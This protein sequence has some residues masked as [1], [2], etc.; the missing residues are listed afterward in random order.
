M[1]QKDGTGRIS[2]FEAPAE[3]SQATNKEQSPE[4]RKTVL[5][6]EK[7]LARNKQSKQNYDK[8]FV[9]NYKFFRGKQWNEAR[10]A[11]R[12]NDVLNFTNAAIQTIIPIMTDSRP[13]I[14]TLPENPADQEFSMIL[15]QVLESKWDRDQFSQIVAEAIVD[16]A[17]YGTAITEQP[18]KPELDQ[19][20]GDFTFSTVD[21]LYC[22]PDGRSRD[23]N[24]NFGHNFITAI[25]WNTG[26]LK[27]KYPDQ[28]H[29]LKSDISDLDQAKTAKIDMDDYRIRTATDSLTLVQGERGTDSD[30][31]DQTLVIT[32]WL[33]DDTMVEEKFLEKDSQGSEKEKFRTKKKFP[34]GRKVVI[35]NK[36]LL[37]DVE[38][39]YIDGK[40]PYAKLVDYILPRE[41]WGEGEVQQLKGP[42]RIIN[43]LW[44][45]VMD[46]LDLMG[47]PV[48]KNPVGS[49]VFDQSI[50]NKPG[51]VIPYNEGSEPTRER[52]TDVQAS[53]FQAFDRMREVFDKISG[54]NDVSRGAIPAGMS[55]IAIEEMK[56]AAETRI[57]LKSRN[58]DAW[59]TAVGQQFVSRVMQFYT[60]ARIVRVTDDQGADK[61]FRFAIDEIEDEKGEVQRVA[62]VQNFREVQLEDGTTQQ[63]EDEPIQYEIKGNLDV[64]IGVGTTLPFRKAQKKALAKELFQLGIYDADDLLTDLEVPNKETVLNK[65]NERQQAA[66]EAE[67]AAAEQ[68]AAMQQAELQI[69]AVAAQPEPSAQA[70]LASV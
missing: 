20:L 19:G 55:G 38:N 23:V 26:E 70:P 42:N 69:K 22:Y 39:P 64:R 60:V 63:V 45:M 30:A 5:M 32:A 62:T 6:V 1:P 3:A 11:Y 27:T 59:L 33:D 34:N 49:G 41:F 36:I 18:Y 51:L 4:A 57:R 58:V 25:P 53:V 29:L 8:D 68:E 16:S 13:N 52:G 40:Y 43:K 54:I 12:N 24:D 28:A 37:E 17:I 9:E 10:P 65:Y 35:A 15:N 2:E 48:W 56:E 7:I 46:T 44:A 31:A 14:T 67:A 61:Y 66:A 21:V 50:V 47:N